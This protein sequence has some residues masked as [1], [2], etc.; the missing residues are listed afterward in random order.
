LFEAG[1]DLELDRIRKMEAAADPDSA[2][3]F[4]PPSDVD[5]ARAKK[6]YDTIQK[7][8][9]KTRDLNSDNLFEDLISEKAYK[10]DTVSLINFLTLTY[11]SSWTNPRKLQ[12]KT[13]CY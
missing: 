1:A 5:K 12:F 6:A 3:R 2:V 4:N 11:F 9:K 8:I 13:N 7:K 10:L